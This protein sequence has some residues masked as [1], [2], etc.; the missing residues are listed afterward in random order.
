LSGNMTQ[1]LAVVQMGLA[2]PDHAQF[3]QQLSD[4]A[5]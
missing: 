2:A 1:V 4:A 5:G 3:V